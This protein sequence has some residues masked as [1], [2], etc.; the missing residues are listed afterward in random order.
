MIHPK[1]EHFKTIVE[2]DLSERKTTLSQRSVTW[3][4]GVA[5]MYQVSLDWPSDDAGCL[6]RL[7]VQSPHQKLRLINDFTPE[8][9]FS[10]LAGIWSTL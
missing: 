3:P 2:I 7:E 1:K 4:G 10:S 9:D 8:A 5:Q 6:Q